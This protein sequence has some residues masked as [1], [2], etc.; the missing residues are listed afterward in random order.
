M[1]NNNE[2]FIIKFWN[3]FLR[4]E[5]EFIDIEKI[6]PI[7]D[8]NN[9]VFSMSYMKLLFSI[10]SE[11]DVVF[12]EYIEYNI[13]YSFSNTD[14]N[15]R[16]Y[17]D[18]INRQIPEFSNEVIIFSKTKELRPFGDWTNNKK[19]IW[20]ENYNSIKHN[21]SLINEGSENYKKANQENILNAFGALYQV[22]MYFYKSIVDKNSYTEKLRMPVPQSKRLRIKNWQDNI[23]LIDNRYIIYVN[24]GH[25]YLEGE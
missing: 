20:W 1:V 14:G 24:D 11:I 6:I 19:S 18:I 2:D 23:E 7:D 3:Y 13:W 12:K 15:F 5:D 4:L 21:R 17:R 16:K 9:N 22:E 25:L 10:C 8:I